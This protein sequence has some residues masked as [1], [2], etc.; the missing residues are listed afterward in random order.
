MTW[1]TGIIPRQEVEQFWPL[2]LPMLAPAIAR[3]GG[4]MSDA[5]VYASVMSGSHLMWATTDGPDIAAVA[6]TRVAQY[7]LKKMLVVECLGGNR[8]ME[9]LENLTSTLRDFAKD[10]G[11]DGLEM[12]GRH[13]WSKALAAYG[14]MPS[15]VVCEMN[16][17]GDAF[18]G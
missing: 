11:L 2:A 1:T 3:S 13:G 17:D 10:S 4:R 5:T 16:F 12:Y 6:T 7:P 8:M 14:W 15:M 9:W 18:N